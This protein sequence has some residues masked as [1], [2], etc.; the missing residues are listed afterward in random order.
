MVFISLL[1]LA[2]IALCDARTHRISNRDLALLGC[3]AAAS[4]DFADFAVKDHLYALALVVV[5]SIILSTF[6]GLGMGDVKL[7]ALLALFILPA[8]YASYQI[9]VTAT[10]VAAALYSVIAS[11]EKVGLSRQI[12]LAPA[13]FIA[14]IATLMAK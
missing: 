13:I 1:P 10:I 3:I 11:R 2:I 7:L 14:T 5:I 9:F 6:C 4:L 12:P 8:N